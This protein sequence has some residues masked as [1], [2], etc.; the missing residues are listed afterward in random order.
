MSVLYC[1]ALW[2]RGEERERERERESG[3]ESQ[4]QSVKGQ[5]ANCLHGAT[6]SER[7]AENWAA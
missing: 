1:T 2:V 5:R 3:G 6:A 4:G 7:R